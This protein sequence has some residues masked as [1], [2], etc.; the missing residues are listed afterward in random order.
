DAEKEDE[1]SGSEEKEDNSS[2]ISMS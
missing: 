1:S 2:E